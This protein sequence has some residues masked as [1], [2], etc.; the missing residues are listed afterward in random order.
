VTVQYMFLVNIQ[1]RIAI[2]DV[3]LSKV[4]GAVLMKLIISDFKFF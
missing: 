2:K 1:N 3:N 4:S